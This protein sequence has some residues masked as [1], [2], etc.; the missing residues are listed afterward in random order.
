[1]RVLSL[2]AYTRFGLLAGGLASVGGGIWLFAQEAR[3]P[4]S[5]ATVIG[6]IQGG[7]L[8]F[9]GGG[10]AYSGEAINNQLFN[11]CMEAR[12]YR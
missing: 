12:G 8:N 3:T 6:G 4:V 11:A 2:K 10:R 9:P 1:M 7:G 5:G